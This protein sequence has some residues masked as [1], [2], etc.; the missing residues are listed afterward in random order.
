M[1]HRL[2]TLA[3]VLTVVLGIGAAGPAQATTPRPHPGTGMAHVGNSPAIFGPYRFFLSTYNLCIV[4]NGVGNPVTIKNPAGNYCARITGV[5]LY[6][7]GSG[8]GFPVYQLQDGHGNCLVTESGDNKV[9]LASA[10]TCNGFNDQAWEL[11]AGGVC[12]YNCNPTAWANLG[13]SPPWLQVIAPN[14]GWKVWVGSS[15]G[16]FYWD[17]LPP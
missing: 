4:A 11:A 3:V 14:D 15:S 12:G 1:R 13:H 10:S 7:V 6:S 17:L 8:N 5:Y 16:Y 2:A 9:I